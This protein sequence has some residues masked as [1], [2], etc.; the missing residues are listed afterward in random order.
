MLPA[1]NAWTPFPGRRTT[2]VVNMI[3][4]TEREKDIWDETRLEDRV[5]SRQGC[6]VLSRDF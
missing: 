6:T 4:K 1:P 5:V 2:K 3:K